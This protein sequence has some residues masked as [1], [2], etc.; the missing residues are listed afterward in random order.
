MGIKQTTSSVDSVDQSHMTT[1]ESVNATQRA[2]TLRLRGMDAKDH[3]WRGALWDTHEAINRGAKAFG[4]WLLTLRGG[5]EHT[6]ADEPVKGSKGQPTHQ[7]SEEERRDRRTLLALSWLSVE[8]ERGAPLD[9]VV[10]YGEGCIAQRHSQDARDHKVIDAL[11]DILKN[12]GLDAGAID[13]WVRD[14]QGSLQARIRADAVWVNRSVAFDSLSKS[15]K[16]LSRT[17]ARSVLEGFFGPSVAWVTLPSRSPEDDDEHTSGASPPSGG[18]GD[19]E[20]FALIARSFLTTNFGTGRK[21]DKGGI[22]EALVK[23]ANLLVKV[24]PGFAG[25]ALLAHLSAEFGIE[26]EDDEVRRKKL[27][28]AIGWNT[29]RPSKGQLA[30]N[31][32][33]IQARLLSQD[34]E[35]LIQKLNE[36]AADKRVGAAKSV[37]LWMGDL[38]AVLKESIGFGYVTERNLIGEFG[39]MLD[40]AARRV[41]IACSWIKLAELER[42]RFETDAKKLNQIREQQ[43]S[44]VAFLEEMGLKR[45]DESG[46]ATSAAIL[47]RKRALVGWKE[48]VGE[49]SRKDCKTVDDR[50]AAARNKQDDLEKFGDINLFEKLA[51]DDARVVWQ[52]I[53]GGVDPTIMERYSAGCVAEA[54]RQRFK[55]PA[56]RHPDPLRHPVFGDFGVSRWEI[57]FSIHERVRAAKTAKRVRPVDKEWFGNSRNMRM[58]LWTGQHV[59]KVPLRWASKR[60]TNDL[61]IGSLLVADSVVVTRADRLGLSPV[62]RTRPVSVASVFATKE[63]NGR[64]QAPRAQLN[65]VA[66]LVDKGKL[67]QA[68]R[69]RDRLSWLVS[70]SPK[71]APMGPF[72]DYAEANGIA[73]N[74]KSGD[75]WPNSALNKGREGLARLMYARLPG[76][77]VLSVDLGHRFAAACAVWEAMSADQ[78]HDAAHQGHVVQGSVKPDSLFVHVK[79]SL[80]GTPERT[81]VF[82]RIGSDMLPD[83]STHPAPW[84]KLERQFL[85][86]LQGEEKSTRMA[87]P[88]EF[89]MVANWESVFGL[90][91]LRDTSTRA[92]R[93]VGELMARA[94]RMFALASRRHFDRARIAHNLIATHRTKPGGISE[95]LT[96]QSRVELITETLALW[97][98]L[99]AGDR[100]TDPKAQ[101]AWTESGLPQLGLPTR[102]EDVGTSFGGPGR[103]AVLEQYYVPLRPHALRMAQTDLAKLSKQWA[104]RWAQDDRQ[105]AVKDGHLS[106]LRKWITPRGLRPISSD[107]DSRRNQKA[108]AAVRARHVGGLSMQRINTLTAL[109]RL[110]KSFKNRPEPNN[111]RKNIAEK[112]DDRLVGFNQRLLDVRDRLREQRVKQLA[113]RVTEAALGIGRIKS[114]SITHGASRPAARVDLPCHAV[115]IESLSNYRPCELQTRRENRQLMEWSS[116]KVKKY[117]TES[118]QLHGLHLREVQPNY[119]S[120]QCSR[121]GAAGLR[122]VEVS[123]GDLLTKSWWKKDVARAKT[124]IERA[125]KEN[126]TGALLD[127]L[128]VSG[129]Q[130]AFRVQERSRKPDSAKSLLS[131]ARI[132]LLRKGGD[133]FIA[134]SARMNGNRRIPALQADLNAAANIGIRSL[135]DPDWPGKWWWVPCMGGTFA[136]ASERTSGAHVFGK[137]VLLPHAPDA[138]S[139]EESQPTQ[140]HVKTPRKARAKVKEV[141]V[142]ENRWRTCSTQELDSGQWTSS[143]SY[144]AKVESSICRTLINQADSGHLTA[145]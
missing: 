71:L 5:L 59:E 68:R 98:G 135:L 95:V 105:W 36:E 82:R 74:R 23:V 31:K 92:T 136:P 7:P 85:I 143:P 56:Y 91:A 145:Q 37:P 101:K 18:G 123:A 22:S 54:N 25:P 125:L 65:K 9:F 42:R 26:G 112:G 45:G 43:P 78:V 124:R 108:A 130:W 137:F 86:K 33:G 29:G 126:R 10:A 48:V 88:D 119:T 97:H 103:R 17:S 40:H 141:R 69:L 90:Q 142:I 57:D 107:T 28:A 2:Y 15:W 89:A 21:N 46:S 131:D 47:I 38:E 13:A 64:L 1:A 113:S 55:V 83:G 61:A 8:D 132:M 11:R 116:S 20:T 127:Q 35:L 72:I 79:N 96:D 52:T 41:S 51:T 62:G 58:G 109:Y 34:I 81:T 120:R 30:L 32:A 111:L 75:Y 66:R 118:C 44:A 49:W 133:L 94:L 99:F 6:I 102:A 139:L 138:H 39:V 27:W 117:L 4:E 93:D 140:A 134:E 12:R 70:F 87:A 24:P 104:D 60:L 100:W 50:I 76:I 63:W 80:G 19:G 110:L 73:P 16:E 115:V 84:A 3:S 122:G 77:R 67:E 106:S 128:L 129:E 14:C 144:W 121:T 114:R 53:D